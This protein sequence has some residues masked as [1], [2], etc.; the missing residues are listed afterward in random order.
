[1]SSSAA[2]QLSNH[3]PAH[4]NSTLK[5][6]RYTVLRKLGEGVS[7]TTWPVRDSPSQSE[8]TKMHET[9]ETKEL[10]ILKELRDMGADRLGDLPLMYDD[11]V[12]CS[13]VGFHLCIVMW[14]DSDSASALRRP[15]PTKALPPYMVKNLIHMLVEALDQLH[16]RHIVHTNTVSLEMRLG[17]SRQVES[18]RFPIH[19]T[20]DTSSFEA[21]EMIMYLADFG[22]AQRSGEQPTTDC[23]GALALRAPEVILWSDFGLGVDIRAVGCIVVVFHAPDTD[24]TAKM[25]ELTDQRF[26]SSVVERSEHRKHHNDNLRRINELI[27]IG[28]ETTMTNY[29][30]PGLSKDEIKKAANSTRASTK[31]EE[32]A[33]VKELQ[34]HPFLADAFKC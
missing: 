4:F 11:F 8:A 5:G 13:P 14:F 21:E 9:S 18:N 24:D 22:H 6:H 1:M 23:I 10:E 25:M 16:E 12:E 27:P 33:T 20:W 29:K 15:S 7:A 34:D 32:Q 26:P 31:Y 28:L 17:G 3:F 19:I 2:T 30:I